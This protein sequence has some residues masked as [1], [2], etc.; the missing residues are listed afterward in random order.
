MAAAGQRFCCI[1]VVI[2]QLLHSGLKPVEAI[3]C[4][5]CFGISALAMCVGVSCMGNIMLLSFVRMHLPCSEKIQ[6][7]KIPPAS[8][9]CTVVPLV[10]QVCDDHQFC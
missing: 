2:K 10:V 5:R 6:S 7:E 3:L 1:N 9:H 4:I 8:R